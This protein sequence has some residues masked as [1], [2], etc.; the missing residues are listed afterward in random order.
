MTYAHQCKNLDPHAPHFHGK[1]VND[2]FPWHCMGVH[3]T[4]GIPKSLQWTEQ[5]LVGLLRVHEI[6]DS[7]HLAR[8][9]LEGP[10]MCHTCSAAMVQISK[11]DFLC[12]SCGAST[13]VS[14]S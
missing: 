4:D 5:S 8:V 3:V 1:S 14:K 13:E 2:H 6:E 7:L 12:I 9:I 11:K 10:M